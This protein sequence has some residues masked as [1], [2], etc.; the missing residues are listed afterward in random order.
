MIT[1][2]DI[3]SRD[4][5]LSN[6]QQEIFGKKKMITKWER[7]IGCWLED[8]H[9]RKHRCDPQEIGGALMHIALMLGTPKDKLPNDYDEEGW[10]LSANIEKEGEDWWNDYEDIIIA[11]NNHLKLDTLFWGWIEADGDLCLFGLWPNGTECYPDGQWEIDR[12]NEEEKNYSWTNMD[13]VLLD[14][15]PL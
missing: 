2:E 4:L 5:N 14:L 11:L 9:L 15:R 6:Y 1:K 13:D 10:P 8:S 7:Y 12:E 3:P